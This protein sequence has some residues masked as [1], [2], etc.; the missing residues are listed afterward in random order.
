MRRH[1]TLSTLAA[2]CAG[3]LLIASPAAQAGEKI[4]ISLGDAA[5]AQLQKHAPASSAVASVASAQSGPLVAKSGRVAGAAAAKAETIHLVEID[6]DLLGDLSSSIH[7]ELNRCGGFMYHPSKQAGLANLQAHGISAVRPSKVTR[8]SYVIDEQAT[9]TPMLAQM[10]ASNIGQTILD[11]SAFTNR[12]YKTTGGVN[13]S[14]WLKQRWSNLAAGRSD[15]TV[16]QFN[17]P[18]WAQKSVILTIRGSDNAREV[19]VLGG[20]LDSTAGSGT[21][22]TTIA[23]GADDDASGIASLTEIVRV[24]MEANYKPRRTLKFMAY[25]AEEVGLRG[26]Q[27]I[28]KSYANFGVNVVGVMQLDMTNYMGSP[29]DIYIYTDYTDAGQNDFVTRLIQTYLPTLQIGSDRCGYGCSD[30]ASWNAQGFAASMPFEAA[31]NQSN[32]RIHTAN[33]TYATSGNQADHALKFARMGLA[34]AVE[35]GTDGPGT[36]PPADKVESFKGSLALGEKKSFGPFMVKGGGALK[37]STVGNG[38]A[39]LYVKIGAPASSASYDCKSDGGSST[40]SCSVTVTADGSVYVQLVG[41]KAS[42][43]RL[44]VSYRPQ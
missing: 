11:L 40:E 37:A 43:Y 3:L 29:K 12:F 19:V 27:E 7:E 6:E 21:G 34:Y 24:L 44:D 42:T 13:A 26:S 23:P 39:D 35:L 5:L 9:L 30:H 32:P 14:N 25:A 17:H 15:V 8:P 16:E 22:E 41:Y 4:W 1:P 20:H 36:A 28:A 10:Q 18:T 33:D 2:V 38:D 31:F